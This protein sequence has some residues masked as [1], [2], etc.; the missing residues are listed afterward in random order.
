[1][2]LTSDG[3]PWP[4]DR[5]TAIESASETNAHRPPEVMTTPSGLAGMDSSEVPAVP[6]ARACAVAV[7]YPGAA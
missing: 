4:P 2:V 5:S 1:M 6:S 3:A 7:L